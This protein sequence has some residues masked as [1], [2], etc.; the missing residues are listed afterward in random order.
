[1][2]TYTSDVLYHLVGRNCPEDDEANFNTL[3]LIL[4]SMEVRPSRVEGQEGIV[5]RIDPSRGLKHG[6]LIE[7]SVT[8]FCDIHLSQLSPIHT[9]KYGRFG[10]GVDRHWLAEWGGRPVIYL[11]TS[12]TNPPTWG[13]R[14]A[15]EVM[16]V[17]KGLEE[18]FSDE[19]PGTKVTTRVCG[20]PP[21][22]PIEAAS[23]ASS[24]I[25]RDFLAF[26]KAYNVSLPDQHPDNYYMEREWRKYGK[27][28]LHLPLR[29]VVV[30][31]EYVGR[32]QE[33]FPLL[34]N[35]VVVL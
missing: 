31:Q 19:E 8:C 3:C 12:Q 33:L 17:W 27:L 28:P 15:G 9:G 22:T 21:T 7:Q 4:K 26:L 5:Y 32:V 34:G 1:M 2:Q 30:A 10:V 13:T 18:H 24:L 29:Q 16:G 20:S 6:E 25:A 23:D 35:K 14:F 11:P